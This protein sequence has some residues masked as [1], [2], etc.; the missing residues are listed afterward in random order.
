MAT[1]PRGA[2]GIV[3][4]VPFLWVTDMERSL[5][6]YVTALGA[7]IDREWIV[8]GRIRWCRLGLGDAAI[9]LQEF[10][11]GRAPAT[12]LGTGQS[13]TADSIHPVHVLSTDKVWIRKVGPIP[14]T[15]YP[16]RGSL[17]AVTRTPRLD[18]VV[19]DPALVGPALCV[20]SLK[21]EQCSSA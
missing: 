21:T 8:D 4:V 15:L 5:R 17:I 18:G 2:G 12:A 6:F 14:L 11:P 16:L 20:R 3:E 9:M 13:K 19:N 10:G 1:T 7:T